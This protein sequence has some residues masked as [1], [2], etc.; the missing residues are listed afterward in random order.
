VWCP[1]KVRDGVSDRISDFLSLLFHSRF[2]RCIIIV[3]NVIEMMVYWSRISNTWELN[4]DDA[5]PSRYSCTAKYWWSGNNK[6]NILNHFHMV[7]IFDEIM[8]RGSL[9]T[10]TKHLIRCTEWQL[11]SSQG[12]IQLGN[13]AVCREMICDIGKEV[14][15]VCHIRVATF[16]I[17]DTVVVTVENSIAITQTTRW[18]SNAMP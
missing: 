13:I 11:L 5:W 1:V 14:W 18:N 17:V 12:H 9:K 6:L 4:R 15:T 3:V 2:R 8:P 16:A 10:R 7:T